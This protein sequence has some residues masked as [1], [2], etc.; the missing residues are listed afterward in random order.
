LGPAEQS[1]ALRSS[2]SFCIRFPDEDTDVPPVDPHGR[3]LLP[4]PPAPRLLP[5]ALAP[6]AKGKREVGKEEDEDM[7]TGK[8]PRP[9]GLYCRNPPSKEDLMA[10]SVPTQRHWVSTRE[11]IGWNGNPRLEW[12]LHANYIRVVFWTGL[13]MVF[14]GPM[15]QVKWPILTLNVQ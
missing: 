15:V 9:A 4:P 11:D 1:E 6:A 2:S 10:A 13:T 14:C 8:S 5:G 7:P 12:Y 3:T